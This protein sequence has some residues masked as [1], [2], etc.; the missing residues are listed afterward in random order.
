[1]KIW[2][3]MK[4]RQVIIFPQFDFIYPY[5]TP[6]IHVLILVIYI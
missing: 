6:T 4:L 3:N 5:L 2:P 1:M